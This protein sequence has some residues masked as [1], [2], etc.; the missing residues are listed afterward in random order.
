MEKRFIYILLTFL[1]LI[2]FG[3]GQIGVKG[4]YIYYWFTQPTDMH[5]NY[6]YDYSHNAYSVSVSIN[7]RSLHTFNLGCEVEYTNRSFIINSVLSGLGSGG[8]I[9]YHYTLGNICI[10]FLPQFVF[11]SNVRF[12]FY[13]GFYFGTLLHSTFHGTKHTW[14]MGKPG[15][16]DT[17]SGNAQGYYPNFEFGILIG[18]GIE[19]PINKTLNL[20]FDNNLSMN[21]LP[22]ATSW[23]S[24]K[25][26]MLNLN[27]EVG[28]AYLFNRKKAV[29]SGK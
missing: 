7:Q 28:L 6:N 14:I 29:S 3:Q 27:F 11:G 4:G 13:P 17:L 1:P 19:Y 2:S 26:K 20:T 8:S 5:Y 22:I 10:K 15:T 24:G 9:D 12:L 25:I 21:I 16:T 18:W 23:G